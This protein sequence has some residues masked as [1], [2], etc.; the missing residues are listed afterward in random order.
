MAATTLSIFFTTGAQPR[1]GAPLAATRGT[2]VRITIENTIS[3]F[4]IELRA[5]EDS[6]LIQTFYPFPRLGLSPIPV[7]AHLR[8]F[9]FETTLSPAPVDTDLTPYLQSK[10]AMNPKSMCGCMWQWKR[11]KPGWSAVK[12]IV[13]SWNLPGIHTSFF[14]TDIG[15]PA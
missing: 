14:T 8:G 10:R 9:G 12:S 13:I 2:I 4:I 11:L 15:Y 6:I 1:A 5:E 7:P 3:V